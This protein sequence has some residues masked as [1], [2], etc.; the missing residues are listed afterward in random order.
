LQPLVSII[1]PIFNREKL[2]GE[3]LDSII[4]QTYTN[5]ECIIV[6]D[7]SSDET[8]I[9]VKSYR[10]KD[11]RIKFFKKPL[12]R[13]KGANACRNYGFEIS[14]GT[15]IQWFDSDDLMHPD[16]IKLKVEVLN[17]NTDH[18]VVCSGIEFMKQTD[19]TFTKWDKIYDDTP[20][21][22]HVTGKIAF[23]TNGPM[24]KKS[25]LENKLLFD[26]TLKRKQEWEFYSRLLQSSV[27]YYPLQK[28]L[29][30]FRI[31]NNSINSENNRE[32]LYSRIKATKLVFK[33]LKKEKHILTTNTYLRKHFLN[34]YIYL[35]QLAIKYKQPKSLLKTILGLLSIFSIKLFFKSL[36][37]FIKKPKLLINLFQTK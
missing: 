3:T 11:K 29:Y 13:L 10:S 31:H 22:S 20:F 26:E 28:I 1:I 12:N 7:C 35:V 27:N 4:Q 23:H 6:D 33:L 19:N 36:F 15:Y 14:K 9:I 32:T 21:I 18:F 37:N 2:I 17:T 25:F 34:K 24:F 16:K 8:E 30:Y 5:W